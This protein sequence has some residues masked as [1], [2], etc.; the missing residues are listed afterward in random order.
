M[1]AG[2][3]G[4]VGAKPASPSGPPVL[5]SAVATWWA[6]DLATAD[7]GSV[8]SWTD[9]VSGIALTTFNTAPTMRTTGGANSRKAVEFNGTSGSLGINVANPV[10]NASQG[11]VIVVGQVTTPTD[12]ESIWSSSTMSSTTRYLA[13]AGKFG[14]GNGQIELQQRNNDT[15]DVVR[16]STV[17]PAG[18]NCLMEWSSSG[19]AYAFRVD[20]ATQTM[21]ATGGANTGDWFADTTRTHFCLGVL[22]YN[23]TGISYNAMKVSLVMVADAELSSGDR[24][25][26]NAFVSSYY[27]LSL[28]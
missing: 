11:C 1:P 5:G 14:V 15:A 2:R 7:G 13:A 8:T 25:A 20:N 3:M 16:G 12:G 6:D 10:S 19:T 17:L 18:T 9:R 21:A 22:A 27:G 4:A 23:N 28:S 26:L 24:A